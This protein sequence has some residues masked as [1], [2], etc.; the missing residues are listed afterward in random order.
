MR[1]AG[2]QLQALAARPRACGLSNAC[3]SPSHALGMCGDCWAMPVASLRFRSVCQCHTRETQSGCVLCCNT[4]CRC[5]E[6]QV[7]DRNRTHSEIA[8]GRREGAVASA[9]SGAYAVCALYTRQDG[10]DEDTHHTRRRGG[11]RDGECGRARNCQA[12]DRL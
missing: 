10:R 11:G 12:L 8:G 6:R 7:E 9:H 5:Q 4:T 1:A 3:D 2:T